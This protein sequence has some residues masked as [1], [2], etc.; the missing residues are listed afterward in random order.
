M[1]TFFM[2]GTYSMDAVKAMS[3]ERTVKAKAVITAAGG[4]IKDAYALLGKSDLVLIVDFPGIKEAMKTSVELTK[5]LGIGF[6]TTPAITV[7][8]FDKLITG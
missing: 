1:A 6:N 8:E 2:F 7:D 3:P 4:K 5:L